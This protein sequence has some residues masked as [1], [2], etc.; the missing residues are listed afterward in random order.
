MRGKKIVI[1]IL[2]L[3]IVGAGGTA[4][5]SYVSKQSKPVATIA[6]KKIPVSVEKVK[7]GLLEKTIPLGGLLQPIEE[8]YLASKN[9]AAKIARIPV[10]V[11]DLVQ[12]GTPVVIFDSRDLDI[13]YNQAQ[14]DYDRNK[15]LYEAG[16]ISQYQFEQMQNAL[17]NLS[18]QK[19]NLMLTSPVNGI[20]SSV[21]AVEGQ[22]AGASPLVSV[23]NISK[24]KLQVQVGENYV[25]KMQ[26]GGEMA[27]SIPSVTTEPIPGIITSVAPNIDPKSKT[28]PITLEI[29]NTDSL[30]KG[31]MFGEVQLLTEKKEGVI[32]IPQFAILDQEQKKFIFIVENE[33]AKRREI[34]VG[35]T[36]GDR[37]E[38]IE[39]LKEGEMLVVEGQYG[40]KDGSAVTPLVREV[41]Q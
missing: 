28:Y 5:Y 31:G 38:I 19:E 12:T 14:V 3:L 29:A 16:A 39:G 30:I 1:T 20:I 10:N 18:L 7:T 2:I 8:V 13:Q 32:V 9:P 23:V 4:I 37:A 26:V 15:Q 17:D 6:T 33:E 41:Q 21:A 24:L 27:V 25:N 22:L 34:K 36:L 35:L 40:L 11:G